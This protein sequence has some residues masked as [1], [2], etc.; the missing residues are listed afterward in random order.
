MYRYIVDLFAV[1]FIATAALPVAAQDYP[2][3]P[4][5]IISPYSAGGGNDA[6]SRLVAERLTLAWGQTVVVEN[7]PGGN[8]MIANELITKA[9]ADGY[10]LIM[11]GDAIITNPYFYAK[12]PYDLMR[13]LTPVGIM[14]FSQLVLVANPSVPAKDAK[15][16]VA[17]AKAKPGTLNFGTSGQGGPDH[18]TILQ[19]NQLA[20]VN[21]ALIPYKGS[22]MAINDLVGGQ[23]QLMITPLA[24]VQPFVKA[25]K[26]RLLAIATPE[27]SPQY[28]EV[29]TLA[30]A[31]VP[32]YDAYW[33]GLMA[34]AGTP[35]RVVA[36]LTDEIRKIQKQP[37]VL[38]KFKAMG[39]VVPDENLYGSPEKF[40]AMLRDKL[41]R[42]GE[43]ARNASV[44]PE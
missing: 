37:D 26:L 30:E 18:L 38:E 42:N 11:N 44:R 27:R 41:A 25:G 2:T 40:G 16:L 6:M 21:I 15:E 4:I 24:A 20:K 5:R 28:P 3:K 29:Q 33:H 7:R 23:V 35:A 31:G 10:T 17:L 1:L 13:D 19:F 43:I 39:V 32:N 14:G 36:R 8:T 9:P 22:S 34:P 12:V